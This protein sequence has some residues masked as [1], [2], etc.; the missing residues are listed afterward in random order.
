MRGLTV[1]GEGALGEGGGGGGRAHAERG[2][3]EQRA[4]RAAAAV[5]ADAPHRGPARP[6]PQT[7]H[8]KINAQDPAPLSQF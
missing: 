4:A 5:R 2:G 6:A 8:F 7:K 1:V 3:P